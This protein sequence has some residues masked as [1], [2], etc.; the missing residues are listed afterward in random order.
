MDYVVS[1]RRIRRQG[2]LPLV[3]T[4]I[5]RLVM[6]LASSGPDHLR[7]QLG[8]SPG[9]AP[10]VPSTDGLTQA[11]FNA[12]STSMLPCYFQNTLDPAAITG[13][14][15]VGKCHVL[16]YMLFIQ[17]CIN[18]ATPNIEWF[19]VTTSPSLIRIPN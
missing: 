1:V 5:C 11:L 10:Y 13:T 8:N 3:T 9:A 4:F 14:V 18:E 17:V 19:I 15:G 2:F 16:L 12:L 6:K 7:P